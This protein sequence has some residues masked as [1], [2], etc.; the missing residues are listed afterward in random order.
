MKSPMLKYGHLPKDCVVIGEDKFEF[1]SGCVNYYLTPASCK[2]VDTKLL[3]DFSEN[4]DMV[5]MHLS[6]FGLAGLIAECD[7]NNGEINIKY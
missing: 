2:F 6:N 5:K 7:K 4:A 1:E 3:S